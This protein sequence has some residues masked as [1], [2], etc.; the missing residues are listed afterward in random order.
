MQAVAE[1]HVA[2]EA[3]QLLLLQEVT[4]PPADPVPD[5]QAI[6]LEVALL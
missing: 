5:G 3:G 2:H 1:V 4:V 6:H